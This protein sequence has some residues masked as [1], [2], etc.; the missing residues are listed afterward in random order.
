MFLILFSGELCGHL[1]RVH[2][3]CLYGVEQDFLILGV[4]SKIQLHLIAGENLFLYHS[5]Q[6]I[7]QHVDIVE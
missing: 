7:V 4:L 6:N 3:S 1:N 5:V 2:G